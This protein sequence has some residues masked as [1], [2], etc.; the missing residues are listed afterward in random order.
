VA[1]KRSVRREVSMTGSN[2]WSSDAL[3]AFHPRS[4]DKTPSSY[5]AGKE[6]YGEVARLMKE[7]PDD[8]QELLRLRFIE[9]F[10]AKDVA[11]SLGI[12]EQAV[13]MRQLRALRQLRELLEPGGP[14]DEVI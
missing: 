7:L 10:S 13:R 4:R 8:D 2:G 11:V 6:L 12:T 14:G 3:S 9:Q 5:V 1:R